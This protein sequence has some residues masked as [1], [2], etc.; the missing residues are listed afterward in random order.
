M[1]VRSGVGARVERISHP[2]GREPVHV[3]QICVVARLVP[4]PISAG[5][6]AVP[7]SGPG[8]LQPP[9]SIPGVIC[10]VFTPGVVSG[11]VSI[12]NGYRA[13]T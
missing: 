6:Q 7:G 13:K 11:W 8:Q 9:R 12:S 3:V 10:G 1:R 5:H 4:G 2:H